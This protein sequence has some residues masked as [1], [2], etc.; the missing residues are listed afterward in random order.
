MTILSAKKDNGEKIN[1]CPSIPAVFE[2]EC[3]ENDKTMPSSPTLVEGANPLVDAS[4]AA[5]KACVS[6]GD[7]RIALLAIDNQLSEDKTR[8]KERHADESDSAREKFF[9][10][11]I[12]ETG[13]SLKRQFEL[14][15][16]PADETEGG[17]LLEAFRDRMFLASPSLPGRVDDDSNDE[18]LS[19]FYDEDEDIEFDDDEIFDQEAHRQATRLR[20]QARDVAA[21]VIAIREETTGRALAMTRRNIEEMFSAHGFAETA[22]DESDEVGERAEGAD[23]QRDALN[24]LHIALD[25]LTASL[26][27]VDPG[28]TKK[29]ESMKETLET[30]DC[31]V[32]KYQRM[33]QGDDSALS[34]TEKALFARD[35][36]RETMV[37]AAEIPESPMNPEKNLAN[38]LAGIS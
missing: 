38:L 19:S 36:P 35:E 10:K 29:L 27:G 26:H 34:Q 17:G 15:I 5:R 4:T 21:R 22:E 28:L 33:S 24:P 3:V 7:K 16:A 23:G 30:I 32:E 31:S 13:E 14:A 1:N 18:S 8:L 11:C 2:F 37:E 12:E 20:G 9:L 25:T 6:S